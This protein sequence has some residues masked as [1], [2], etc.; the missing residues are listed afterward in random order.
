[1]AI[2]SKKTKG[3]DNAICRSGYSRERARNNVRGIRG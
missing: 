1:M 3:V 2:A